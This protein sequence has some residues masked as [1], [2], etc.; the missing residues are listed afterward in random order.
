MVDGTQIRTRFETLIRRI[1]DSFVDLR[2][3]QPAIVTG[4][5]TAETPE[6]WLPFL[7]DNVSKPD[8]PLPIVG[9]R[10]HAAHPVLCSRPEISVVLGSLNRFELLKLAIDSVR[11]ELRKLE[12]EILV[13]D[14][15][16]T[17]G[18]LEWLV[19]QHDIIT[20]IQ[21][22]RY[23]ADGVKRRRR[24]WGGFMNIGFRAAAAPNIA[25]IS[26]DCLLM[27]GSLRNALERMKAARIAGVPVGACAFYFRDWPNDQRYFVQRTLGG[28]LMVNHGIYTREAL[29]AVGYANE[30]D[31]VFYKAD[32]DLSLKIWQSG[33][34]I[35][36]SP[37]SV[38]EHYIG[39]GETLRQS[40]VALMDYDRAQMRALWSGLVHKSSVEKMGKIYLDTE[41][42]SEADD[43]WSVRYKAE[44]N[45]YA[46]AAHSA[47]NSC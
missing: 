24:S 16:S 28:N 30:D 26:D 20:L 33:F 39:V 34:C 13:V 8:R 11:R 31:Y 46:S 29:E 7:P 45:L 3:A 19:Q 21:H 2:P 9:L 27:P 25:M 5:P 6:S 35:I 12:G 40:N 1:K 41:P 42:L 23:E 47:D 4:A 37:E 38:C 43:L 18:S 36:D 32:T 17:D 22:N 44:S 14:G 10:S 15:G